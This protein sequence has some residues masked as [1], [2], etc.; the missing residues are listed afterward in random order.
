MAK[1]ATAD[2]PKAVRVFLALGM[3][4]QVGDS[5]AHGTCWNCGKP[6]FGVNCETGQWDCKSCGV[7]GNPITFLRQLHEAGLKHYNDAQHLGAWDELR[8]DRKLLQPYTFMAWGIIRSP[9]T[10]D[11]LIPAYSADGK[12]HQLYRYTR[13]L[14]D[15]K[16]WVKVLLPTPGI[17]PDGQVHGLFAPRNLISDLVL[18]KSKAQ[19]AYICEGLWDGMVWWEMLRQVKRNN[20][21]YELTGTVDGSLLTTAAVM[22][23]PGANVF[24]EAWTQPLAGKR[25]QIMF[26]SDHPTIKDGRQ[27]AGAGISGMRRVSEVLAVAPE[28]C[29]LIRYLRWGV[30][31]YDPKQKSGFDV[32]DWLSSSG[33]TP[34]AR[35][36]AV[37]SIIGSLFPIP[38]EWIAGRTPAAKATGRI[39]LE[40]L[41]CNQWIDL[42]PSWQKALMWSEPGVGLDNALAFSM[43]CVLSTETVGDQLW[44]KVMSP[45]SSGK[46]TI[47]E[48]LASARQYIYP[49]STL[50]GIYS[51]HKEEGDGGRD[52]SLIEK[53]RN[54]TLV[55]KDGDTLMQSPDLI[56]ILSE[57]R[58]IYDRAGRT[59]FRN[60]TSRQ[61]ENVNM[62]MILFGTGQLKSLDHSEVGQR[63]LDCVISDGVDVSAERQMVRVAQSHAIRN[64]G[65]ISNCQP[66]SGEDRDKVLAKQLTGGYVEYL[67]RGAEDL[68]SSVH[69]SDAVADACQDLGIFVACMRARPST[70]QT[71]VAE[72]EYGP[73][74]VVQLTRLAGCMAVV[75]NSPREITDSIMGRVT[76]I[77]LDTARGRTLRITRKLLEE[78]KAG[79]EQDALA[80]ALSEHRSDLFG[81]L[82]YLGQIGV[83]E[84]FTPVTS[85]GTGK[86]RRVKW[87]L[88]DNMAGLYQS[89]NRLVK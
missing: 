55:I 5:Q 11:W 89:V 19:D 74:L 80:H 87:R 21:E 59:E 40:L 38:N 82:R 77:A 25:V 42:I 33:D 15:D 6:K 75:L 1:M 64:L 37:R 51:G 24:Q 67:R 45:P 66:G 41:P 34:Q 50:R 81:L 71:E 30:N 44:G 62:T 35:L 8:K 36:P 47:A 72:R 57:L 4:I 14:T 2:A 56:R 16:K 85:L 60:N 27:V 12:L 17:W 26:D 73:R 46:T 13:I 83:V 52:H 63:Y 7:K 61:Y 79:M 43:S 88:T 86:V 29:E 39:E 69:I 28:Q 65:K 84:S 54:K 68:L 78:G 49:V 53:I 18:G 48:A 3:E 9:I 58:D 70:T 31:G 76:R 32:R 20:D 22:A 23:T 10:N